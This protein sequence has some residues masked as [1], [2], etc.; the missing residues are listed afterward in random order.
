MINYLY[1]DSNFFEIKVGE[2]TL[3]NKNLHLLN[4]LCI[5]D[6]DLVY[7]FNKSDHSIQQFVSIAPIDTKV[8]YEIKIQSIKLSKINNVECLSEFNQIELENLF[9]L[10]LASGKYSRFNVDS[11]FPENS[12]NKLY[13]Q[14]FVNSLHNIDKKILIV[15]ENNTIVGILIL[16]LKNSTSVIEILAVDKNAT[17]KGFA[18]ALAQEAIHISMQQNKRSVIVSTQKNNVT[19]NLFYTSIGFKKTEEIEIYH[20]WK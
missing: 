8:N 5:E 12:F 14:W 2:I 10:T 3:I 15:R 9:S 20:L 6:Y 17:R 16:N 1:W 7:L 11:N 19:A 4:N 18:S 13:N